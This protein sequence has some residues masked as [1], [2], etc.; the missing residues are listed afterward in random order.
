[1]KSSNQDIKEDKVL[2]GNKPSNRTLFFEFLRLGVTAFGGPAMVAYIRNLSVNRRRWLDEDTFKD[3]I[4]LCQSIPG[5]TAMQ[6]AAYVGLMTNGLRGG[7]SAYVGFALPA[8]AL[9]L[10]LSIAYTKSQNIPQVVSLFNGLQVIVVA[11]IANATYSFGIDILKQ[12]DYRSILIVLVSAMLLWVSVSPFLVILGAA[13]IGGLFLKDNLPMTS[14]PKEEKSAQW[15]FIHVS[16]LFG[17]VIFG[18][19]CL[20]FFDTPLFN[21][22][23]LML[24]IDLFAFGGAFASVPLMLHEVVHVRGWLDS[25][26]LMDGIALGQVTPGPIVITATFVGYLMHSFLGALVA[27]VAIFTPSFV[28][29]TGVLPF[30]DRIRN[31]A[32]FLKAS[33]SILATFVGLLLYATLKFASV[34]PWD[35][36]RVLLL[37]GA[38]VALL[39]KT[40]IL[41]VV[42]IC[43]VISVFVF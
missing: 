42:L 37:V 7:L 3:G 29:L 12:K 11:L 2:V 23:L 34:V 27:T 25:K 20:Y 14:P 40:D 41:Y 36:V 39:K 26:T 15:S 16:F 21:L 33:K 28:I 13:L 30:Y 19:F 22:A 35:V 38:L 43:S 32:F 24:K 1:L 9:M 17:I 5:A 8:F 18:L 6:M 4:S 10:M 31:S